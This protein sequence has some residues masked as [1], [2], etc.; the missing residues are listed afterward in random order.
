MGAVFGAATV[1]AATSVLGFAATLVDS[2]F[3]AGATLLFGSAGFVD[4]VV[5]CRLKAKLI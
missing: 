5:G 1:F 4:F 2:G 3:L